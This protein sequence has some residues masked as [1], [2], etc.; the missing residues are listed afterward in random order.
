MRNKQFV[1]R[2]I[3]IITILFWFGVYSCTSTIIHVKNQNG[4]NVEVK[5]SSIDSTH[6]DGST[7]LNF[8]DKDKDTIE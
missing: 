4:G 2:G 8:K 6:I 7:K 3:V 5:V 1:W